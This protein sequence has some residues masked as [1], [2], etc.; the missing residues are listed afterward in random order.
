MKQLAQEIPKLDASITKL[1]ETAIDSKFIDPNSDKIELIKELTELETEFNKL[2][3]LA[4]KYNHQEEKLDTQL[5]QFK[6][7]ETAR[8]EISNRC[9]LWRS[10]DEFQM[11]T[12]RWKRTEFTQIDV[13]GIQNEADKYY[14]YVS[15][16]D[17]SLPTNQ[18][19]DKLKVIVNQFRLAM[20]IVSA[21]SNEKLQPQHWEEINNTVGKEILVK[22]PGFTLQDLIALDV[23]NFQDEICAIST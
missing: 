16:L 15:K 10:L 4:V 9:L 20:P 6:D 23:N 7:L 18:V 19:L 8:E 1:Y 22:T 3:S 17:K 21:L 14:R 5:T 13:K 2:D 12:E 11:K